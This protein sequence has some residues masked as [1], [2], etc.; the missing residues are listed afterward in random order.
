MMKG[1]RISASSLGR[2]ALVLLVIGATGLAAPRH[3]AA[4]TAEEV[5]PFYLNLLDEGLA[6]YGDGD[7]AGAVEDLTVACFGFLDSPVRLLE[8][9]VYLALCH[10]QLKND[11]KARFYI[12]EIR[13]L[14]LENHRTASGLPED[15]V[16]KFADLALKSSRS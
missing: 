3:G 4:Q 7:P 5:D 11:D 9:Y 10:D 13:R 1:N 2:I 15:V 8:G 16:K 6:L 12:Q 14:R